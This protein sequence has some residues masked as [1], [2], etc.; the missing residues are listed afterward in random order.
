MNTRDP[1]LE[2]IGVNKK[3]DG[4]ELKP[5]DLSLERGYI[6]G[7][8]GENGAGKT[9]TIKS[10]LNLVHLDGGRI[11]VDGLDSVKDEIKVKEKIGFVFDDTHYYEH[12]KV[13]QMTE[14]IR[15]F[16]PRW[17][18][19]LYKRYIKQFDLPERKE[20]KQLSSGMKMKYS[21]AV[22]LSHH[23]ELI[24][25]DEPTSGLDPVFRSEL[26]EIFQELI[27]TGERSIF[28][29][30]HIT[31]DLDQVADYISLIHHGELIFT[32]DQETIRDRY[33]LIKGGIHQWNPL[34]AEACLGVRK[35]AMSF[36]GLTADVEMARKFIPGEVV[37]EPANLEEIMIHIARGEQH[38]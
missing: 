11:L 34:A 35:N 25:L 8:I 23:A 32:E 28:F 37:I 21:L 4:F 22:A 27:S 33:H 26:L 5:L 30:S 17:D 15:R 24:L 7:F 1:I 18:Q 13:D 16:Y 14:I 9:T 20:I 38:A 36:S 3:Y 19:A 6:M 10:V 12:L 29:S 2:L 31:S